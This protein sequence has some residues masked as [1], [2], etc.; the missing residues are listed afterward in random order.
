[1]HQNGRIVG[2]GT[3]CGML[4]LWVQPEVCLDVCGEP[5]PTAD[6]REKLG[7]KKLVLL[8]ATHDGHV[9]SLIGAMTV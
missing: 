9:S 3:R 5:K 4:Q 2:K 8:V 1:M 6:G 7:G